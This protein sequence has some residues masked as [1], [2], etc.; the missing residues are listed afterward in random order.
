MSYAGKPY[1]PPGPY[2]RPQEATNS[3]GTVSLVLGIL[4]VFMGC[5]LAIAA[6]ITGWVGMK[7]EP[8]GMAR[9][10]FTIGLIMTIFNVVAGIVGLMF[11]VL[12]VGL[13]GLGAYVDSQEREGSSYSSYPSS[14]YSSDPFDSSYG[15]PDIAPFPVSMPEPME[16]PKIPDPYVPPPYIPPPMPGVGP[17]SFPGSPDFGPSS[18]FGP[19]GSMPPGAYPPGAFPPGAFPPGLGPP[20]TMETLSP[21]SEDLAP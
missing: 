16:M 8:S 9:A 14:D 17:G 5:P 1:Q 11:F 13:A 4:S 20:T 10:G 18:G 2:V 3:L 6:L 15:S 12:F 19:P 7:R 21:A